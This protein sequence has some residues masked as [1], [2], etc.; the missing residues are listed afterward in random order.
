M[1][2]IVEHMTYYII[3]KN[4][5]LEMDM[6]VCQYG[7]LMSIEVIINLIIAIIISSAMGMLKYGIVF[8]IVFSLLRAFAG[9]IHLKSFFGCTVFSSIILFMILFVTKNFNIPVV[10]TNIVSMLI[11]FNILLIGPADDKKRR[12]TL[13]EK[14]LFY[15]RLVYTVL[16]IIAITCI[17]TVLNCQKMNLLICLTT[18]LLNVVQILAKINK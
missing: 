5:N 7:L 11:G 17:G 12:L 10:Y 13:Y 18:C 14:R 16:G 3:K 6:E 9:G 1:N 8:L 2:K 4:P 15:H